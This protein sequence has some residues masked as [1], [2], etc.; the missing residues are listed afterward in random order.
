MSISQTSTDPGLR[1]LRDAL[2]AQL[3]DLRR[4][5]RALHQA[6]SEAGA[7]G[8]AQHEVGDLKDRAG[9]AGAQ[10]MDD[11]T[12]TRTLREAEA[13]EAA[14][15]RLEAGDYGHCE[16]C[17]QPIAQQRLQVQPAAAR[18]ADCQGAWELRRHV[19]GTRRQR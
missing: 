19:Q 3:E 11:E 17:G 4:E 16:D 6:R 7:E 1:V 15:Q 14:L 8:A 2:A 10:G 9:Q 13:T 5:L 12:E 18:C